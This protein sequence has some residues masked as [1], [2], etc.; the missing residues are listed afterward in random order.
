MQQSSAPYLMYDI[1]AGVVRTV[2]SATFDESFVKRSCGIRVHDQARAIDSAT[3]RG[4]A[5][6][7]K[8]V[9]ASELVFAQPDD[10]LVMG[11]AR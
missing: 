1:N 9:V 4:R 10:V 6:G 7:K 11:V 5:L 8:P 2:F 3:R